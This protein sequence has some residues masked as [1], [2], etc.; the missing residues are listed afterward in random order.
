VK[1][2]D[3]PD[4]AGIILA[5]GSSER[6]GRTKQLL[7]FRGK[8]LLQHVI[9]LASASDLV[10]TIV[11][12]GAAADEI[13]RRIEPG[14][15]VRFARNP[16]HATGQ[17]SSLRAGLQAL[18]KN[19]DAALV[20]V[21]DQPLVPAEAIRTILS[22]RNPA[23][24]AVI[25]AMYGGN[26]GHPVLLEREIW[27]EVLDSGSDE[28][29]RSWIAANADRVLEADLPFPLPA[30]VDTPEDYRRLREQA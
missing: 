6:M 3:R 21:G 25:R 19:I 27:S 26:P 23:R 9:E 2:P 10:E 22:L 4:V 16:D 14:P 11:V 24:H 12:L 18:G 15:G 29:A 7:P 30:E 8:P 28:G 20:L 17:A 1:G 5:A 13:R